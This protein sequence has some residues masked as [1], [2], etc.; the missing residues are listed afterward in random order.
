MA[1]TRTPAKVDPTRPFYAA[2]GGVDV[3][4][5]Y[6]RTGLSEAQARL[7]RA[8]ARLAKVDLE[9]RALAGELQREAK[10]L[11]ARL[12]ALVALYVTELSG[13]FGETVDDLNQQY[14]DL[15]ARGRT[16]VGRIRRQQATQQ[17]K[18][19]AKQTASRAKTARTQT[20]KAAGTAKRST[21]AT[22]TTAR[23]TAST[24]RKAT[25][26]GAAKVGRTTA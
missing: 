25:R 19:E 10:A 5:G 2:V 9:P 24:A 17:V 8:Q 23:K 14:D 3:A 21:K 16:L 15:A 13:T 1:S 22:A 7:E 12:E 6:A 26:D 20:R 18:A 4:V 11:P